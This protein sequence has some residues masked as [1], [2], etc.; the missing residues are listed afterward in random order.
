MIMNLLAG[1]D[2]SKLLGLALRTSIGVQSAVFALPPDVS[3]CG[4]FSSAL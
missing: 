3:V 2:I 1:I 4:F